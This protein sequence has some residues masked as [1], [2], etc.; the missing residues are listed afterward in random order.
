MRPTFYILTTI[1]PWKIWGIAEDP[2]L[3]GCDESS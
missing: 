1:T 2:S 3:Q